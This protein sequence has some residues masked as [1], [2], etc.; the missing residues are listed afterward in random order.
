LRCHGQQQQSAN[1]K[2]EEKSKLG[3]SGCGSHFIGELD[4]FFFGKLNVNFW[5]L[6]VLYQLERLS[7][8]YSLFYST[9]TLSGANPSKSA[10]SPLSKTNDIL[11]R[12][13]SHLIEGNHID[14]YFSQTM[15]P[16]R[17]ISK[18]FGLLRLLGV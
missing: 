3:R 17:K 16:Y 6:D 10:Q 9:S 7:P 8:F 2:E 14:S 12:W 11:W 13:S 15:V 18:M 1:G 4:G 5:N